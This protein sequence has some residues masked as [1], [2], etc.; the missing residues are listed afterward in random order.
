MNGTIRVPGWSKRCLILALLSPLV[1]PATTEAHLMNTGFGPFYDGMMHLAVS[2]D[3]LL[4]VLAIAMLSGLVSAR[5]GRVTLLTVS[6]AWLVGGV[7]GLQVDREVALS[8]ASTVSFLVLGALVA[9]DRRLPLALVACLACALGLLHG[10]LNGTAMRQIGGGWLALVGIAA[11]VF[12]VVALAAAFVVSL[13]ATWARV[14][15]RVAGSWITAIGLLMLG[16]TVRMRFPVGS[17]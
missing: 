10:F 12:V 17:P 14:A 13:R 8:V 4:G 11:G 16:W 2:P 6:I 1:W 3:D 15:V 9:V 7:M 5:H